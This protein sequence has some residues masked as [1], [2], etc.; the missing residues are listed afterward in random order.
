MRTP[1]QTKNSIIEGCEYHER[2]AS[3]SGPE[4]PPVPTLVSNSTVLPAPAGYYQAPIH[5]LPGAHFNAAAQV[6]DTAV[7]VPP[8]KGPKKLSSADLIRTLVAFLGSHYLQVCNQSGSSFLQ[9]RQSGLLLPA[10]PDLVRDTLK[11]YA[12]SFWDR[13][14]SSGQVETALDQFMLTAQEL[15]VPHIPSGRVYRGPNNELYYDRWCK[16]LKLHINYCQ[17]SNC[18]FEQDQPVP[19]MV[20]QSARSTPIDNIDAPPAVLEELFQGWS[21]PE[22]EYIV[23]I[24]WMVS[25]LV[26]S[27][28][29]YL[30][31]LIDDVS[32]DRVY[33]I[34]TII[35]RLIDDCEETFIPE[36][37]SHGKPLDEWA[38]KHYLLNFRTIDHLTPSQQRTW[39]DFLNGRILDVP[40][41]PKRY[42]YQVH[43]FRPI[44]LSADQSVISNPQLAE[45]TVTLFLTECKYQ[46]TGQKFGYSHQDYF[47][48][49][50]RIAAYV[51]HHMES[52]LRQSRESLTPPMMVFRE[53]G[54]L[55]CKCLGKR[56]QLFLDELEIQ[57][58]TRHEL[59]LSESPVAQA[60]IEY[61]DTN[62]RPSYS[63]PVSEW[64][65][66]LAT[67]FPEHAAHPEWPKTARAMGA[68][69][70]NAKSILAAS[71]LEASGEKRG[72]H[73]IWTVKPLRRVM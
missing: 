10:H 53:I 46:P 8:R 63:M 69:L 54:K 40:L 68:A 45:R 72:S 73:R 34:Q 32:D 24:S 31:E 2:Q 23:L 29:V 67:E 61:M 33:N 59:S 65:K 60:I 58:N 66:L 57:K 28:N 44:L 43:A 12:I 70:K 9:H 36:G 55:V 20:N 50:L 15:K 14:P 51:N 41:R 47:H 30:L 56:E 39:L 6:P 21:I 42:S 71:N 13:V 1:D 37:I 48:A 11:H 26:Y 17:P 52:V 62:G 3:P 22:G 27:K 25:T 16:I 38:T 5:Q 18:I 19:L 49:F 7:M 35:K 4:Q 64:H